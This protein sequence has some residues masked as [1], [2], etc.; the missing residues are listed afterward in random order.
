[1]VAAGVQQTPTG[2]TVGKETRFGDTSTDLFG[3]A[4]TSTST[5][6]ASASYDSFNP[7]GGF[8]LIT[9]MMPGE[10]SPGGTGS[11]LYTIL[12]YAITAVFIGGLMIG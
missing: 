10:V 2:N 4:S 6:S 7:M 3:V 8:G 11:G 1:V 12:I 5:G 9:G